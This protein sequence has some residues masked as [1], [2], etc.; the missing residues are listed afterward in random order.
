MKT[1]WNKTKHD[2]LTQT[3]KQKN[4]Q[5]GVTCSWINLHV[6]NTNLHT[7]LL[8]F[9]NTSQD[10]NRREKA[11]QLSNLGNPHTEKYIAVLIFKTACLPTQNKWTTHFKSTDLLHMPLHVQ[12]LLLCMQP[13]KTIGWSA[14]RIPYAE[15]SRC[16]MP[17]LTSKNFKTRSIHL[18]IAIVR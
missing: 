11:A 18:V 2:P 14:V 8:K 13:R 9:K 1:K 7:H 5:K 15:F 17:P 12:Q 10:K 4:K 3:N 6:N 16:T